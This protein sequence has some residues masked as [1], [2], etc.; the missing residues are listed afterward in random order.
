M[1]PLR[2]LVR[3]TGRS[4][5]ESPE[6]RATV[7]DP[8]ASSA[9]PPLRLGM[10]TGTLD[11][12]E[13]TTSSHG[14]PTPAENMNLTGP[15]SSTMDGRHD[16]IADTSRQ[17]IEGRPRTDDDW[18][19][20]LMLR[21]TKQQARERKR[22]TDATAS[23]SP[24]KPYER[25]RRTP[26]L[27]P[28]PKE[29]VKIVVRPHQGMPLK[30]ISTPALAEAIVTACNNEIRGE[31]FLLR[32]KPCSNIAILSTRSQDVAQRARQ[33]S[34][35]TVNG[36]AHAVNVYAATGDDAIRG[37]IHGLP[38]RTPAETI[39]ANLPIRTQGVELIHARM[40]GDTK[41][42]ALTFSGPSLPR[43]VYYN[44]GE[45]LC[46]P[47][48]ATVQV[49]KTCHAKG[50][51]TDVCPQPDLRLCHTCGLRDPADGHPCEPKCAFA[52]VPTSPGIGAANDALSHRDHLKVDNTPTS[53]KMQHSTHAGSPLKMRSWNSPKARTAN[54][55]INRKGQH[56]NPLGKQAPGPSHRQPVKA[57]P[58]LVHEGA[59]SKNGHRHYHSG[60]HR[61]RRPP[62]RQ[63][64]HSR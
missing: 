48:R 26:K 57:D 39:K 50:H 1:P 2:Y 51:R 54:S 60:N 44:G 37:V 4:E 35:L 5:P 36:R 56:C 13:T 22:G 9:R 12:F 6:P 53:P 10:A 46:H 45:L 47:Y 34:S 64:H 17:N 55:V 33:I 19:T 20:V 3:L 24:T 38:P 23:T 59:P 15:G 14:E 28:L 30:T 41:S 42:A 61:R 18:H 27:P 16:G 62:L 29:D 63:R 52:G 7:A 58:T 40:I 43:V 25:R 8:N 32:I 11:A 49:C 21:Q 31:Q